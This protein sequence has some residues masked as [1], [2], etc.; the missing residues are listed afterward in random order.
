MKLDRQKRFL[1]MFFVILLG[2]FALVAWNPVNDAVIVP[3][4][5]MITQWSAATLRLVGQPVTVQSTV[6]G[7]P[8]FLVD[9]KNGCNGV[10]AMLILLAAVLS[11]PAPLKMKLAG[12][13]AG[14]VLIQLVNLIRI[15]S[16]YL[17]GRYYPEVF[18]LFHGAI[19]QIAVVLVAVGF[20]LW[21][22]RKVGTIEPATA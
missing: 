21:W 6:M 7:T 22:S 18:E 10:E 19:W 12:L 2:S 15:D 3:F 14:A 17:L 5:E 16:L 11:F 8:E 1:I 9:V 13:G 20:F 4:T